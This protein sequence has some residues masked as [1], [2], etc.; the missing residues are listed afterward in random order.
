MVTQLIVNAKI[1]NEGQI[2]EQDVL[3]K[4]GRIEKIAPSIQ[5]FDGVVVI[6]AKGQYL[7][8]GMIDDQVHFREPGLTHKGCIG[9]ESKAAVMGGV[10]S[11]FE[12]PNCSPS[13]TNLEALQWKQNR[14][15]ETSF[16]NYAFYL[17]ASNDNI[18]D[19]R[20]IK[21]TQACGVK[22][23]MGASTGNLLV[24][25]PKIL[26]QIFQDCPLVIAVH[27]E[28]TPMILEQEKIYRERFG[29]DVPMAYHADI[30]SREACWKSS[31][32][33]VELAKKHGTRLHV[34]HLTSAEELALFSN[35]LPLQNK[36]ITAEVCAH[37]LY[38]AR[39]DYES[40][41]SKIKC[42]PSI[43]E[44]SDRDALLQA[45]LDDTIDIIATDHAPHTWEEKQ[46]GYFKAPSGL[47]LVQHPLLMLLEKTRSTPLTLTKMV[48]K[49]SH[50]IA[51]RFD[52][53]DRGYIREGY[54]ADLVLVDPNQTTLVTNESLFYHCKW[55]PFEN[56]TF[57][58]QLTHVW[59]NGDM[60]VRDGQFIGHEIR[61][62]HILD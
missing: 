46:Q 36:Q 14:A 35:A 51:V 5:A 1:V 13:T 58:H 33:A 4:S 26:S 12:M 18:A 9:T 54:W 59:V 62:R 3:I 30:R 50:N 43:K 15:K 29:E 25:D 52:L 8:P 60:A 6:D 56:Q 21:P 23:F 2:I 7:I 42:N 47:P 11:F 38:F 34:L 44:A 24:D 53:K 48:Q 28:D 20:K 31:S 61:G 22:I 41:G 55:S 32:F 49:T 10:T 45:V 39:E 27:C 40:Q 37:H 16:A 57:S 17:G 19:I